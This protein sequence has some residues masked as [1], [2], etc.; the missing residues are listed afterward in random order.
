MHSSC[1]CALLLSRQLPLLLSLCNAALS[2]Q[3]SLL[4]SLC[5]AA[6][7]GQ[8]APIQVVASRGGFCVAGTDAD[9]LLATASGV[10]CLLLVSSEEWTA[11]QS[12][13]RCMH[14]FS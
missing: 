4:L 9:A 14:R 11:R 12:L 6:L 1:H 3:L 13:V 7:S 5:I 8:R 2:K 10:I